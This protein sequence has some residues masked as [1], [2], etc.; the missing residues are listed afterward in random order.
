MYRVHHGKVFLGRDTR[1]RSMRTMCLLVS[2]PDIGSTVPRGILEL[3]SF[4]NKNG[5]STALLPL[6]HHTDSTTDDLYGTDALPHWQR[7]RSIL[8]DALASLK[9]SIVGVSNQFTMHYPHCL[10]ILKI[11][12]EEAENV[13]TVIGGPHVTFQDRECLQSPWVDAVVRGEGEWTMLELV[14]AIR[15]KRDLQTVNGITL[16]VEGKIVRTPERHLGDLREL[17]PVDFDLFPSGFLKRSSLYGML[18]RG[19]VYKCSYCV[20]RIFWKRMRSFPVERLIDEMKRLERTY[21]TQMTALDESML[22]IGS[23]RLLALCS[24]IESERISVPRDFY[25][26]SRVD[27]VT[28]V[29]IAALRRANV[30]SVWV[31]IESASEKVRRK[32]NKIMTSDQ[33]MRGCERMRDAG[34][35]IGTFWI[36]GHPGDNPHEAQ[37]SL[38]TLQTMFAKGLT[39]YMDIALFVPYPG[40][41][42]FAHPREHGVQIL[43]YDWSKWRRYTHQPV[44]Q[45][46]DFSAEEILAAFGRGFRIARLQSVLKEHVQ[47]TKNLES[48]SPT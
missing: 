31:G 15:A 33:I 19:C 47:G 22:F 4:L 24:A 6:S 42:F 17:P 18:N 27:T 32:M 9:P 11:C 46:D 14:S 20:E 5:C 40:T 38:D 26:M 7:I 21:A 34:F 10:E 12:K 41:E 23:D 45:L 35:E 36:I 28:D 1:S 29:G 43:T 44:C 16:R 13:V 2:P 39:T 37:Y 30:K 3:G 48:T 25:V 8:R